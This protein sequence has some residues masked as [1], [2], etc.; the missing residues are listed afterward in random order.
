MNLLPAPFRARSL[1]AFTLIEL[2]V[3]IAIIALLAGMLLP[4][5]SSAKARANRTA[6]LSN[7]HQLGLG[8]RMYSDDNRSFFP[9][10]THETGLT[11]R[12]WIHTLRPYIGNTDRVRMC[13]S[14]P[15]RQ[16]RLTNQASS[17]IPN[18]YVVVD[19]RDGFGQ[20]KESFRNLDVLK[21]PAGTFTTFEVTDNPDK[22]SAYFDHTHSRN[23][24]RGWNAVL[25]DI[26]PDRHRTGPTTFD[27]SAGQADYLYADGHAL[28]MEARKLKQRVDRGEDVARP[29]E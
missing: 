16:A 20:V 22:V 28:A 27:H 5:L 7:L 1:R 8:I 26:Q 13:P 21:N 12:S 17:Y 3:V 19:L 11:N 23:W 18:G 4:A 2:L 15:W 10:T 14:D 6:C 9:E 25:A 24:F 29:P